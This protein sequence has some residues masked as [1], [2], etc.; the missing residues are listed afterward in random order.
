[1]RLD[2]LLTEK[3]LARSRTVAG[4]LI[5]SG[6]V[7]VDGVPVTKPAKEINVTAETKIQI[8]T[9]PKYVGRGGLKL[10]KA[11]TEFGIDPS[12]Q[13][14]LDVGASTGGFTDCLLQNG[15][16]K[17]YAVDVGTDQLDPRLKKDPRVISQEQTDIR[18]V[19]SLPDQIDLVVIDVSFISLEL[20]LNAVKSLLTEKGK[21]IALVKPQFE[22]TRTEKNKSG[23]VKTAASR[24][25][26]LEKL[27][28]FCQKNQ[29]KIQQQITSP[30][31]GGSGN[32]E[33][34]LLLEKA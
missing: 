9:Q 28:A 26:V 19:K 17:V 15:A 7:T 24:A 12:G 20:V 32:M 5:K 16:R 4:T 25:Q 14:V 33:Y 23:V 6:Q 31:L 27:S 1:M 30:L 13:T 21:I 3:K 18:D 29:L 11:L 22:T 34:L 2:T 8:L 10:E